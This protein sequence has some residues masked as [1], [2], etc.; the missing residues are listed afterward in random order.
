MALTV[1]HHGRDHDGR[2]EVDLSNLSGWF[3]A[4]SPLVVSDLVGI[5]PLDTLADVSRRLAMWRPRRQDYGLVRW[6]GP[7]PDT[8]AQLREAGLPEI[9]FNFLGTLDQGGEHG[10]QLREDLIVG[11]RAPQNLRSFTLDIVVSTLDAQLRMDWRFSPQILDSG[12]VAQWAEGWLSCLETLLDAV[13]RKR[14]LAADHP[15]ARLSQSEIRQWPTTMIAMLEAGTF[16]NLTPLQE[17]MLFEALAYGQ[18]GA[19]HEQITAE[20]EGPLDLARFSAAWHM[21]LDRHAG[22]RAAFLPREQGRP[23]Q[24]IAAAASLPVTRLDWTDNVSGQEARL[25]QWLR[26]DAAKPFD[27]AHPPLMR[28]TIVKLGA[29]RHRWIWSHHHILL[30]GWSIP[31]FFGEVLTLYNAGAPGNADADAAP[32]PTPRPFSDHLAWLSMRVGEEHRLAHVGRHVCEVSNRVSSPGPPERGSVGVFDWL[33]STLSAECTAALE[34]L[35]RTSQASLNTVFNAAWA[36]LLAASGA[37][38][39]VVFGVTLSGRFGGLPGTDRMLGMFINTLPLRVRL[40]P[41]E[42][43]VDLLARLQQGLADLHASEQDR[44]PDILRTAALGTNNLFDTLLVFENYPVEGDFSGEQGVRFGRPD[45][46]EH[47]NYPLE[48]AIIPSERI[49]LRLEH[50]RLRYPAEAATALVARLLRILNDIA[51]APTQPLERHI[52]P[53]GVQQPAMTLSAMLADVDEATLPFGLRAKEDPLRVER[54]IQRLSN[55]DVALL[56]EQADRLQVSVM[57]LCH[58]AWAVVAGRLAGRTDSVFGTVIRSAGTT[59][60]VTVPV[61]MQLDTQRVDEAARYMQTQLDTWPHHPTVTLRDSAAALP[62]GWCGSQLCYR[63]WPGDA[64]RVDAHNIDAFPVDTESLSADSGLLRLDIDDTESA[65]VVSVRAQQEIGAARIAGYGLQ[66]IRALVDA[67]K[68]SPDM[69]LHDLSILSAAERHHVLYGFN[70]TES[71]L[72]SDRP[73]LAQTLFERHVLR[74]PGALALI[75]DTQRLTYAQ[76]NRRANRI[77]HRLLALGV[78]PDDLVVLFVERSVDMVAGML[79]IL[80]AGGAYVPLD[81]AYPAERLLQMAEDSR[82]RIILSKTRHADAVLALTRA[83]PDWQTPAMWLDGDSLATE[84]D[85]DLVPAALG[86]HDRHLAYVM[87]TSGSTGRP[88]GVM[89]EHRS[90]CNQIAALQQRYDLSPPDRVL[91]FASMTFDMSV[92]E[93]FGALL[94]GA[95]LVLRSD[96]WLEST[97]AFCTQCKAAAVSVANL[98]TVFWQHLAQDTDVVL[99]ASLRQI[100]IGGEAVSPVALRAW[101]ARPGHLPRLFNAYGPTEATVNASIQEVTPDEATHRSIGSPLP[102]TRLYVL[103]AHRHPVPVGVV[104][105]LYIGGSGVARG[106]LHRPE[107]N[108]ERFIT[109]PF[110][111]EAAA[112]LYRTGDLVCWR[113][114]GRLDYLGRNDHQL[115]VRGFRI[116]PEEIEAC[117]ASCAGVKQAVVVGRRAGAG[118]TRLIAYYLGEPVPPD[119][120]SAHVSARLPAYMVPT[121][122][123]HL[124]AW[125]LT[126]NSKLDRRALPDPPALN[127]ATNKA[128]NTVREGRPAGDGD[129]TSLD[130]LANRFAEAFR[131]VLS[132]PDVD[133]GDDY[134]AL[135]GDSILAMQIGA[136]MRRQ[137]VS[138]HPG[139]ILQHRTPANLAALCRQRG[140][141]QL[142]EAEPAEA[143]VPLLPL[144]DWFLEKSGGY[145]ARLTL[146]VR[147][148]LAA[149]ADL[150]ALRVALSTLPL[151]HDALRLRLHATP[152][153][154]RQRYAPREDDLWPLTVENE[155]VRDE[156]DV[157][158]RVRSL[159]AAIDPITGPMARA[160]YLRCGPGG[161]PTLLLVVHHLIVDVASWHVLLDELDALYA[162]AVAGTALPPPPASTSVRLWGKA[163]RDSVQERLAELPFWRRMLADEVSLDTMDATSGAASILDEPGTAGDVQTAWLHLDVQ[164]TRALTGSLNR[165]FDTQ[166][167]ALLL[168]ALTRAWHDGSNGAPLRLDLEG[169]GRGWNGGGALDLSH[170]VGWLTCLYPLC[171]HDTADRNDWEALIRQVQ[172]R[173]AAVPDGGLGFGVLSRL[174]PAGTLPDPNPREI[175]WNYLGVSIDDTRAV[176]P[177]LYAQLAEASLPDGRLASDRVTHALDINAMVRDGKL[178]ISFAHSGRTLDFR[179]TQALANRMEAALHALLADLQ[180]RH[181]DSAPAGA[182]TLAR[183]ELDS[184]ML[185]IM[186]SE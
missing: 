186:D 117:L 168:A 26:D 70:H 80:K 108:V 60:E 127:G 52:S 19:F 62:R 20:V 133:A 118:Q 140:H 150:P 18:S 170:T 138:V 123:V 66:G 177:S 36:L 100:M 161:R 12:Q 103:D 79:G 124:E 128:Y 115:K 173:L 68:H 104:G 162:A 27:L 111:A 89:I 105:E 75:H 21:M 120:L 139:E 38:D 34:K 69:P 180:A 93:I 106:Y 17:G 153:G 164:A 29:A 25:A 81:P 113:D 116:E 46:H 76:L 45:Y 67:L 31:L 37:G 8:R 107:L 159:Q 163:L 65:L 114:D 55:S 174:A 24:W 11:E 184:L 151:R 77:A 6:L 160:A 83:L 155:P 147:L 176:L 182:H 1:E 85:T 146:D 130:P 73:R 43:V 152:S 48:I 112:R 33:D 171:I 109:D 101:F 49:T 3:T 129:E 158:A 59:P 97:A 44:L 166:P 131:R 72:S 58:L 32:L 172:H 134:F 132:V 10:F 5:D 165:V 91:Q 82:P 63:E 121:A 102:N 47:S 30:D 23:V 96:A 144:Q 35:A 137:G 50:D 56:R 136:I 74:A 145:P 167:Q 64:L 71:S 149:A 42:C 178:A 156:T 28:L 94:S 84:S 126:P 57:C 148:D 169:H 154:W 90:L 15:L 41:E 86:L 181:A 125:P 141:V 99:P 13:E 51:E 92:E 157:M 143:E 135:G 98:P 40:N 142:Y 54:D 4:L 185:D 78:R 110:A 119:T 2:L 61:R 9:S 175:C 22:L 183:N 179:W 53:R 39:D 122:Y 16:Y 14:H 7:D 88:K 87:Y 95:A